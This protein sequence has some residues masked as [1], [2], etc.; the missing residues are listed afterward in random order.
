[1]QDLEEQVIWEEGRSQANFLYACQV[2][3]YTSPPEL[4]SAL[5]TSYHIL[6]GQPPPLPPLTPLQRTSPVEEQPTSIAPPTPAPKQSP[7]PRR[8]HPSPDPVESMPPGR[9]TSKVTPVGPP[10]SQEAR[11]PSLIQSTQAELCQGI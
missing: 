7:R 1:M 8:Q 4:K 5:A 6:L 9:I 2:A 10:S 11:G 3:L